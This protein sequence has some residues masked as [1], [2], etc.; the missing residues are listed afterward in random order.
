MS[1]I[2]SGL[3]DRMLSGEYKYVDGQFIRESKILRER[4]AEIRAN[5]LADDQMD[6]LTKF[7]A[8]IL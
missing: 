2:S 8:S 4:L 7:I 3:Q 5:R 6:N 1:L